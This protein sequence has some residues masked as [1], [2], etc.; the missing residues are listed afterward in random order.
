MLPGTRCTFGVSTP[1]ARLCRLLIPLLAFSQPIKSMSS[2]YYRNTIYFDLERRIG[3]KSH[4]KFVPILSARKVMSDSTFT[5]IVVPEIL[6]SN[7]SRDAL[8]LLALMG[9]AIL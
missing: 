1:Q 7:D 2:E 6:H 9:Y 4:P 5:S 3:E 8:R